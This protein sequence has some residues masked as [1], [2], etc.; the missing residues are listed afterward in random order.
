MRQGKIDDSGCKGAPD[1]IIEVLSPS[2]GRHDRFVK[3]KLY[4]RAGVREYWIVDAVDRSVQVF[5]LQDG[6]YS[7]KEYAN[8]GDRLQVN[9]LEGCSID[10]APVF[11]WLPGMRK[12]I[13]SDD[14]AIGDPND[15]V[16]V[17]SSAFCA[18]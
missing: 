11:D 3:Y 12:M 9:V 16:S 10:L 4:E 6:R 5:T 15:P 17:Y 14:R 2:H 8:L 7:I 1:L 13:M 18:S